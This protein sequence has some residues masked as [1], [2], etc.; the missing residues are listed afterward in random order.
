[1][2][3]YT[4]GEFLGIGAVLATGFGIADWE[5]GDSPRRA[6]SDVLRRRGSVCGEPGAGPGRRER[7]GLYDR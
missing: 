5:M 3:D 4:R 2:R 6:K 7:E 1:M